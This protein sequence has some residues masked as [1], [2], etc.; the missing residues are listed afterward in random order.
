[1]VDYLD[2]FSS[3]RMLAEVNA[4]WRILDLHGQSHECSTYD[5]GGDIDSCTWVTESDDCL[6]VR[7][8]ALP[9]ADWP[10]YRDEWRP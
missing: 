1:M 7:L 9:Y 6:T 2:R 8:L 10:G 5:Q 3:D 4:K